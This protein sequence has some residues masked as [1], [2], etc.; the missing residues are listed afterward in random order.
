[1]R[2]SNTLLDIPRGFTFESKIAFET[3]ITLI[4]GACNTPDTVKLPLNS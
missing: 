4:I 2:E 3:P 1:M